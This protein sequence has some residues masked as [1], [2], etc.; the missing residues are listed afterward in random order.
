MKQV[1]YM[2][3]FMNFYIIF[4]FYALS[5]VI[6]NDNLKLNGC[7]IVYLFITSLN[8]PFALMFMKKNT[9]VLTWTFN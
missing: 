5:I 2:N 3:N 8:F 7:E 4:L 6:A 9:G 1:C